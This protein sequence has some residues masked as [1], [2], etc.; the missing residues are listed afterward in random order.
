M[1][2]AERLSARMTT[3]SGLAPLGRDGVPFVGPGVPV[4]DA[5]SNLISLRRFEW[6]GRAYTGIQVKSLCLFA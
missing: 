1:G 5:R 2:L 4:A 3:C 6:Y